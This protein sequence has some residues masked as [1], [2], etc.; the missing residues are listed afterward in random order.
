MKP[1]E[2]CR[3][4]ACRSIASIDNMEYALIHVGPMPGMRAGF[5]QRIEVRSFNKDEDTV[6][7]VPDDV[8]VLSW[9]SYHKLIG[10]AAKEKL[11]NALDSGESPA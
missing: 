7:I 6:V 5:S 8:L 11:E 3:P 9:D 2:L 10:N 1:K 4:L